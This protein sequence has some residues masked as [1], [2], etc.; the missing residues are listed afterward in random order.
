MG[1]KRGVEKKGGR[2]AF[3][4]EK[5]GKFFKGKMGKGGIHPFVKKDVKGKGTF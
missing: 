1:I 3:R 2:G 4:T 5:K